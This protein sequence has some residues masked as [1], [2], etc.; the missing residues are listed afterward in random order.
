[1]PAGIAIQ[2][3]PTIVGA[4]L[5][6]VAGFAAVRVFLVLAVLLLGLYI[7]ALVALVGAGVTVRAERRRRHEPDEPEP[8]QHGLPPEP[9]SLREPA[10][11]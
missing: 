7:V 3:V 5:G 2:A 8:P 4:Y 1:V 9:L 11:R 6:A 10:A